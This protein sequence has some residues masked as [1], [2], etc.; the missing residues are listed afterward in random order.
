M[1]ISR[2]PHLEHR[3]YSGLAA[4]RTRQARPSGEG[5]I[6]ERIPGESYRRDD[7]AAEGQHAELTALSENIRP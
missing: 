6:S 4:G 3:M 1:S 7:V 5:T 2:L